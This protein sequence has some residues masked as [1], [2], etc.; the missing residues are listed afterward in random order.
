MT[1]DVNVLLAASR[2]DHAH[3]M[4]AHGWLLETLETAG[5]K[6]NLSLLTTVIASFLR[7][8]THPKIFSVPTPIQH[9]VDFID[10]ILACPGVNLLAAQDEWPRLR[11]LCLEQN[12]GGN[13]M[14]DAWIAACVLQQQE[15]LA[16]FDKDFIR[17]LP[18]NQLHLLQPLTA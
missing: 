7:L 10:A 13:D 8:A 15:I 6:S 4:V 11:A 14:P 9:A 3:H 2:K 12:L 16:T 18:A 1:P 5:Q 17:L